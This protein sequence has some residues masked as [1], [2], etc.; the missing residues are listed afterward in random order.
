MALTP[1]G[2]IISRVRQIPPISG[3]DE[4]PMP[5]DINL[6][7]MREQGRVVLVQRPKGFDSGSDSSG[8]LFMTSM[9]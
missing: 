5:A 7:E 9:R 2:E 6:R 3:P 8:T 4:F 1:L